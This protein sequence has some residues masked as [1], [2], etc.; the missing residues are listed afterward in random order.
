[1]AAAAPK[2][3]APAP[4]TEA[5]IVKFV[6]DHENFLQLKKQFEAAEKDIKAREVDLVSRLQ[7]NA[8]VKTNLFLVAIKEVVGARR[9]AWKDLWREAVTKLGLNA[10]AEE[11]KVLDSIKPPP[12]YQLVITPRNR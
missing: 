5:D 8:K 7:A 11:Q 10:D 3:S 9:P 2:E 1:M 12:S 4:I 6:L